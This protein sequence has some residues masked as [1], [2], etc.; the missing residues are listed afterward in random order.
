MAT[1]LEGEPSLPPRACIPWISTVPPL[2]ATACGVTSVFAHGTSQRARYDADNRLL[3]LRTYD[4]VGALASVETHTWWE[5]L[6]LRGR[7]DYADGRFEQTEWTYDAWRR[8][9]SRVTTGSSRSSAKSLEFTY[10]AQGRV[11]EVFG[12]YNTFELWSQYAYDAQ[13]RLVSINT[14]GVMCGGGETRCATL[15]YWPDGQLKRHAWIEGRYNSYVDEYSALGQL[16]HSTW[17]FTDSRG[18]STRAYDAA[19]RQIRLREDLFA[20]VSQRAFH[21]LTTRVHDPG[22]WRERFAR[23]ALCYEPVE[24][25]GCDPDVDETHQRLT[26]RTT[27]ICGTQLVALDEWDSNED[28]VVD[29]HRTHERDS[30]GRLVREVYSGTAGLDAGPVRRDF[31]Y[32]CP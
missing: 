13:G 19:G 15:S 23:D 16:I 8:L 7:V 1:P 20:P 14:E 24:G 4:A 6:E 2:E 30:T 25:S 31:Q 28:G 9:L 22:G 3:E 10:D 11:D 29:A 12:A 26:R 5:D 18:E 32:D 21:S 27:L 17:E